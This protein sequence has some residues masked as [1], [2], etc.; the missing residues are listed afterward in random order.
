MTKDSVIAEPFDA[1][2]VL[3][4]KN[5]KGKFLVVT[6]GKCEFST[7]AAYALE[8]GAVGVIFVNDDKSDVFSHIYCSAI[9]V[10][11]SLPLLILPMDTG[12]EFCDILSN[13]RTKNSTDM[14]PFIPLTSY[15]VNPD[16]SL[17][18]DIYSLLWQG[19]IL[20]CLLFIASVCF[21]NRYRRFSFF[22][23]SR[24]GNFLA[25]QEQEEEEEEE[26]GMCQEH[27]DRLMIHVFSSD[28]H[29]EEDDDSCSICLDE[30]EDGCKRITLPCNGRHVFHA[31]CIRTWLSESSRQCPLCKSNILEILLDQSKNDEKVDDDLEM[32][33]VS[34][35]FSSSSSS[36]P[37]NQEENSL[38]TPL[39]LEEESK[40][41]EDQ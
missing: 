32:G 6:R 10:S 3:N 1:C 31:E 7:K 21:L 12:N 13:N 8:V 27:V 34:I 39:L 29:Q 16:Q 4:N 35:S 38:R 25:Q 15:C 14:S 9:D 28:N 30:Y 36:A 24:D 19:T 2:T 17:S 11:F 37:S 5:A 22:F 26:K 18:R 41:E 20:I 33:D 23:R 40:E